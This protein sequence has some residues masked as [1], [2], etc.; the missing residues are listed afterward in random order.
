MGAAQ[1]AA[2]S[3]FHKEQLGH[4]D[5]SLEGMLLFRRMQPFGLMSS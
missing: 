1:S 5:T 4:S 3:H 2:K